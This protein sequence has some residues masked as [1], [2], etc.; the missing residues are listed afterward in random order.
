MTL[1]PRSDPAEYER[2]CNRV[3]DLTEA[4]WSAAE[5]ASELGC[6]QRTVTRYRARLGISQEYGSKVSPEVWAKAEPLLQDG[7]SCEEVGRTL[8]VPGK[9]VRAKFPQYT[10]SREQVNEYMSMIQN[11]RKMMRR[12]KKKTVLRK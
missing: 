8:G 4:G 2:M 1:N 5:I 11:E 12:A 10:W 7:A 3:K 9:S 6:T